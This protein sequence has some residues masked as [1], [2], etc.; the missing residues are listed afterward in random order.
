MTQFSV[1]RRKERYSQALE[2]ETTED[3]GWWL[4]AAGRVVD[5]HNLRRS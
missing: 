4:S 1:S 2:V 3:A 5:V